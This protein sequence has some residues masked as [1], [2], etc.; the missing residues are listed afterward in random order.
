[1]LALRGLPR[2]NSHHY[3]DDRIF[4]AGRHFT[5]VFHGFHLLPKQIRRR[6]DSIQHS[7]ED[8]R[9][10]REKFAFI[11][12][13]LRAD[14]FL[15][16]C[17]FGDNLFCPQRCHRVP[18]GLQLCVAPADMCGNQLRDEFVAAYLWK[19]C[20]TNNSTA[21]LVLLA[22]E[23]PLARASQKT[24]PHDTCHGPLSLESRMLPLVSF[25]PVLPLPWTMLVHCSSVDSARSVRLRMQFFQDLLRHTHAA[26]VV[27]AGKAD[28]TVAG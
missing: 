18:D 11:C 17:V 26:S 1:M 2:R 13:L 21:S 25:F 7:H 23:E 27:T 3:R 5:D 10:R 4:F 16:G 8:L 24:R 6:R 14:F 22:S 28:F 20:E 19:A 12:S 9:C 15:S